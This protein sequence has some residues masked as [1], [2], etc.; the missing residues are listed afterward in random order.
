MFTKLVVKYN[1][2]VENVGNNIT[3][4]IITVNKLKITN[5]GCYNVAV[6]FQVCSGDVIYL[7][8]LKYTMNDLNMSE[9]G[10]V[11]FIDGYKSFENATDCK[12]TF[13]EYIQSKKSYVIPTREDGT[14]YLFEFPWCETMEL[15]KNGSHFE[16]IEIIQ[17]IVE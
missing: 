14:T 7:V 12:N 11:E 16:E 10:L 3:K 5:S 15:I 8:C 13:L 9:Q 4:N 6:P 1:H 2:D 17:L